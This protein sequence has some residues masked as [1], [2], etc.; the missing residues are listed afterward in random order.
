MHIEKRPLV[1]AVCKVRSLQVA[2]TLMLV[3][4]A[5]TACSSKHLTAEQREQAEVQAYEAQIRK[6][7]ADPT[8]AD[9]LVALTNEFQQQAEKNV[10]I[11]REYRAKV[12][13]LNS[14]YDA[15]R[16]QFQAL[17][18]QQDAHRELWARK[19]TGLR[20]QMVALTSDLEWEKLKKAR[21]RIFEA[22]LQDVAS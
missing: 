10:A 13:A 6:V 16:E 1:H 20:E 11:F 8:R 9:R 12:A 18:D 4:T 17:L 2:G 22:E 5:L 15:T 3:L 21:L 7:V 19:V 14:N